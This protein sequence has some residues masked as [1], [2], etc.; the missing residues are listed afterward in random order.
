MDE[1][2]FDRNKEDDTL[3]HIHEGMGVF[4]RNDRKLG[5]VEEIYFGESEES[6]GLSDRGP[7]DD[8]RLEPPA[9]A[10]GGTTSLTDEPDAPG[11]NKDVL[12]N[13]LLREGYVKVD[14]GLLAKDVYI[15]PEQIASVTG[16]SIRLSVSSDELIDA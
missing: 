16:D 7:Q 11:D 14:R 12:R 4:D 8:S 3:T 15:L 2:V 5:S 10:F 13:R 6:A 9:F 1:P